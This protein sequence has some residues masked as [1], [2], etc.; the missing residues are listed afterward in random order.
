MRADLRTGAP[1]ARRAL[2]IVCHGF[3]GY[4][5]W[6]FFPHLSERIAA[7]GFHVLTMSFSLCGVDETTGR[8][9]DADAFARNTVS[10]EIEDVRRVARFVRRGG[11]EPAAPAGGSWGLFGHSRGG[12]VALLAAPGIPEAR[13][14]VTWATLG[15]LDR[16]TAR[17]KTAWRR[18]GALVFDDP[19]SDGPLRLDWAYYE[20]IDRHRDAFDLPAAAGRLDVP[21]LMVHGERD[22]AVTVAETRALLAPPRSAPARLEILPGAGHAFG[23]RHPMRRPSPAL[24]RAIA[25]SEAWFQRTLHGERTATG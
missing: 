12:A 17:R 5:R 23:A 15:R 22:A 16:Y 9:S 21:H 13:S 19:R 11:L 8:F 7:A 24:E 10:A 20:D 25:L 2:V 18:D 6:G 3:L 14:L 1:G 4:K